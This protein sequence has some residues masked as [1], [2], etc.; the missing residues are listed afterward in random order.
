MSVT[1]NVYV[2]DSQGNGIPGARVVIITKNASIQPCTRLTSGDGG[3]NL[4][5]EGPPFSPP[6]LVDIAVDAAGYIPWCTA[7]SPI[8]FG[9][10]DINYVLQLSSFNIPFKPAPRVWAGNMC[11][12][13]VNDIQP[14]PGGSSDSSLV[15]SWFYDR[16]TQGDRKKIRDDWKSKGITHILVSWP[17]SQ[18]FGYTPNQFRNTCIELIQYGFYPCPMLCAKPSNSND[19]RTVQETLDNIMLVLPSL[20]GIVPLFCVGWELSLWLSP[21]EVQYLIDNIS[22]LVLGRGAYLYV[23]FQQGYFAFQQDGGTTADFWWT[24]QGK[25]YGVLH[26]RDLTWDKPMYQARIVD[27]LDRFNGGWTFPP[28]NGIDGTAFDFVALEITAQPQFDGNMT[29]E[30]G[31]SWGQTALAVPPVGIAKVMGSGNGQ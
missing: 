6:L 9:G 25:L 1:L 22:P 8:V 3:C 15:L 10:K 7:D 4:Y 21:T 5:F 29:E 27:C 26:Q 30:E 16:Y 17:D 13:R 11:G 19:I 23:H 12:V 14:V 18:N 2:R 31:N 28:N 24:N 20:L